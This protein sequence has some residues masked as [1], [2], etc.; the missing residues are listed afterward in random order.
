[1]HS[2]AI[3]LPEVSIDHT[4]E[5]VVRGGLAQDGDDVTQ[6]SEAP[7]PVHD[8]STGVSEHGTIP[9][10]VGPPAEVA[11]KHPS[12]PLQIF[13]PSGQ[14]ELPR[15]PAPRPVLFGLEPAV[16]WTLATL[17]VAMLVAGVLFGTW[18]S[19]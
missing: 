5:I 4:E 2:G 6:V 16:F 12:I 14:I 9:V 18:L 1:M 17:A 8:R 10:V 7:T 3:P 15:D 13:D 19:P 11:R